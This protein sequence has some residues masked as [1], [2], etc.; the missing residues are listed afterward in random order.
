MCSPLF[1]GSGG[2]LQNNSRLCQGHCKGKGRPESVWGRG[3]ISSTVPPKNKLF[4]HGNKSTYQHLFHARSLPAVQEFGS[5]KTNNIPCQCSS[6][7][8]TRVRKDFPTTRT[9][10]SW[11]FVIILV[12]LCLFLKTPKFLNTAT[13]LKAAPSLPPPQ[14]LSSQSLQGE[15]KST[16]LALKELNQKETRLPTV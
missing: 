10:S 9:V 3:R 7:P 13:T 2:I 8:T 4:H 1:E 16:N 11:D 14:L 12:T 6:S 5:V 15:G